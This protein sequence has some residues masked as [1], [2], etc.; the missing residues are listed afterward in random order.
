MVPLLANFW[1]FG[2]L[3]VAAE[4]YTRRAG[5]LYAAALLLFVV[6]SVFATWTVWGPHSPALAGALL[7]LLLGPGLLGYAL[8]LAD[9]TFACF[10]T[11]MTYA[12]LAAS[13]LWPVL[14]LANHAGML[15]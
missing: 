4:A 9:R 14:V 10:T 12:T 5:A 1:S 15:L 13:I 2:L 8:Y 6:T 11:E 3:A 7:A